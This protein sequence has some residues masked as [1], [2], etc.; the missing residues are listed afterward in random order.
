MDNLWA[1]WR[2]SYIATNKPDTNTPSCFFCQGLMENSDK[3]NLLLTRLKHNCIYLNKFPYNNGH[4]LI[5][6]LEHKGDLAQLNQNQMLSFTLAIRHLLE[7]L[8]SIMNPDGFNIGMNHGAAAGAGVPSH[9]HWHIVPRWQGDTNFM[10]VIHNTKVIVQSLE[11][12][13]DLLSKAI[14]EKPFPKEC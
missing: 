11:S 8:K 3:S 13:Y 2:H 1:P 4:L 9:L 14:V 7:I 6:P 5:A 10:P 12:L